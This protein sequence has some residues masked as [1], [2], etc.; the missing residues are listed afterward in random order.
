MNKREVE[1]DDEIYLLKKEIKNLTADQQNSG[2]SLSKEDEELLKKAKR[3]E[4]E[5]MK[6]IKKLEEKVQKYKLIIKDAKKRKLEEESKSD[7]SFKI[8]KKGVSDK[9]EGVSLLELVTKAQEW[10]EKTSKKS[11]SEVTTRSLPQKESESSLIDIPLPEPVLSIG[12]SP[13]M[14]LQEAPNPRFYQQRSPPR[15][16]YHW[17]P[18]PRREERSRGFN[19]S[20]ERQR[21]YE[22]SQQRG[23][24]SQPVP[25][26]DPASPGLSYPL[27]PLSRDPRRRGDHQQDVFP[28]QQQQGR[29]GEGGEQSSYLNKVYGI[30]NRAGHSTSA[31]QQPNRWQPSNMPRYGPY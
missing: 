17:S 11:E 4:K 7:T 9:A 23:Y 27:N 21:A 20:R 30:L 24:H 8:P 22:P 19:N 31:W 6:L 28:H 2:K 5:D 14:E 15:Q 16:P 12:K 13:I 29:G 1:N 3:K 26:Y 10:T 18:P 25:G